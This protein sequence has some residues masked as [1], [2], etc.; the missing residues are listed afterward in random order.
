MEGTTSF[1]HLPAQVQGYI[2]SFLT[3]P[4]T[5]ERVSKDFKKNVVTEIYAEQIRH[6][7]EDVDCKEALKRFHLMPQS[8]SEVKSPRLEG[9]KSLIRRLPF[10]QILPS[11]LQNLCKPHLSVKEAYGSFYQNLKAFRNALPEQARS[12][13]T[14]PVGEMI[15]HPSNLADVLDKIYLT[16][17]MLIVDQLFFQSKTAEK[18]FTKIV[19]AYGEETIEKKNK[20]AD[21]KVLAQAF[22]LVK[23]HGKTIAN[24]LLGVTLNTQMSFKPEFFRDPTFFPHDFVSYLQS[25][26]VH[27]SCTHSYVRL[28]STQP[29]VHYLKLRWEKRGTNA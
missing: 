17:V 11:S 27:L 23:K 24:E 26:T 21:S 1:L 3:N 28:K 10:F 8:F 15:A 29:P 18:I 16:G 20:N 2:G 14:Q 6:A 25:P 4:P 12:Y 13:W 22:R 9:V 19:S 7:T 5:L